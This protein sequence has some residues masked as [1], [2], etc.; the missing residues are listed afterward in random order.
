MRAAVATIVHRPSA[1]HRARGGAAGRGL[2]LLAFALLVAA[3]CAPSFVYRPAGPEFGGSAAAHYPIPPQRPAG[4]AYVTS[5]GFTD[6][7][8][9]GGRTMDLLH[10]RIALQNSSSQPWTFDGR[11]QQL[12]APGQQQAAPPAF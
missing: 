12:Q 2:A 5:F 3:G 6:M 10:A 7:D 11:E 4:E 9:G 1:E 8:V